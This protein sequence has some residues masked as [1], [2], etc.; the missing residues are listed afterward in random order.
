MPAYNSLAVIELLG[1]LQAYPT[2]WTY[3]P[4]DGL[5]RRRLPK[6]WIANVAWRIVGDEFGEFVAGRIEERNEA[7]AEGRGMMIDMDPDVAEAF[8]S[9]NAVSSKYYSFG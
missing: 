4:D 1:F 5:E 6:Q 7:L 2:F 3:I 9:S 8:A